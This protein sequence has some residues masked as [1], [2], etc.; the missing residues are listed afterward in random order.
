MSTDLSSIIQ[1]VRRIVLAYQRSHVPF[2]LTW[3]GET[4]KRIDARK[5][6]LSHVITA[7]L[8]AHPMLHYF[9]GYH[10][11]VQVVLLVLGA[12]AAIPAV[13]RL[14]LLRIRDVSL[15]HG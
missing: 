2:P 4:E 11:I 7:T 8:R 13:A 3:T 5:H 10:D 14:S 9:Q 6:E 12:E 15:P 1:K